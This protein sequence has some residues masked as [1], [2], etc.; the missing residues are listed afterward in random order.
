[1]V[2]GVT[3]K[4]PLGGEARRF[5][6]LA[7]QEIERSRMEVVKIIDPSVDSLE[8]LVDGKSSKN[9]KRL[10]NQSPIKT[11]KELCAMAPALKRVECCSVYLIKQSSRNFTMTVAVPLMM[12]HPL[13]N[14][15]DTVT[16]DLLD[17]HCSRSEGI[18]VRKASK[19]PSVPSAP[20]PLGGWQ[21]GPK[22]CRKRL[23]S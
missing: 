18:K 11:M 21:S 13:V 3:L 5:V 17:F 16:I 15:P 20:T 8:E 6:R 19:L 12:G 22:R 4:Q 7:R 23:P 1:L 10:T 9:L 14:E 2:A